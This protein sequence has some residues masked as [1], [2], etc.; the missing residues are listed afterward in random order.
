MTR[1]VLVNGIYFKGF[2]ENKFSPENTTK[3]EFRVNAS[4]NVE[5]D[6]MHIEHKF[7]FAQFDDMDADAVALP[8]KGGRVSMVIIL[9]RSVDG[10]PK[11][12]SSIGGLLNGGKSLVKEHFRKMDKIE[13]SLPRFKIEATIDKL[14]EVLKAVSCFCKK[15]TFQRSM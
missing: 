5:V 1:L 2:W 6:M 9:P 8:Y 3:A 7:P 11:I 14:V 12:Q 10:L 4:K 13:L 15:L